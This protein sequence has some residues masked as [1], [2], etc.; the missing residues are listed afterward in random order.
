[1][2][3]GPGVTTI[4]GP[5]GCGKSN[6]V[7]AIRW[8][9]GEQSAKQLR[10]GKMQD[11]IFAGTDLR[12][13]LPECEVTLVF[14]E[15]E[16][17]L[18]TAYNE[19]EITRRVTREGGSNYSLNGKNCRL[20]DIQQLFMDTGV[21]RVSYSFMVQGQIDQILSTNPAERRV[22]FEE[23]AGITKYKSQRKETLGKLAQVEQ[24]LSR[25]NDI[26][27]EVGR[28]M[29]SLKRQ[30]SKAIRYQKVK[31]RLNH[32]D[33]AYS[34]FR[35]EQRDV[36]I[37]GLEE[38]AESLRNVV[39][40]LQ[41]SLEGDEVSLEEKREERSRI[42]EA[43]QEI[44]QA[45][46]DIRSKKEN[47]E[48]QAEVAKIRQKSAAERIETVEAEVEQLKGQ[49]IDLE[50]R[51]SDDSQVRQM[52]LDLIAGTDKAFS[53]KQTALE[54]VQQKLSQAEQSFSKKRSSLV[55]L[56]GD[57]ARLQRNCSS[58][59]VT[60]KTQ[61]AKAEDLKEQS[62]E[63]AQQEV[64]LKD[65]LENA[66]ANLKKAEE[67][68]SDAQNELE[69]L[70]AELSEARDTFKE[71]Q[72]AIQ[73]QDRELARVQ[74][75]LNILEGLQAKLE[76]FS[77]GAKA[78]LQGQVGAGSSEGGFVALAKTL[79]VPEE[80]SSA[81]E[82]LM[83]QSIDAIVAE[84]L[85]QAHAITQ[86]LAERDLGRA[87]LYVSV[88]KQK[89]AGA[90]GNLPK[91]IVPAVSVISS[92]DKKTVERLQVLL[93]GCYFSETLEDF[94]Q[95]WQEKPG[96]AFSFVATKD[97]ELVDARGLIFGG[98]RK[99][100]S[101][102]ASFIQ[103]ES[104]IRTLSEKLEEEKSSFEKLK[105]AGSEAQETLSAA[106]DAYE[107][108]RL[109]IQDCNRKVSECR[110]EGREA[111]NAWDRLLDLRNRHAQQLE[112]ISGSQENA[113]KQLEAG[114]NELSEQ[115]SKIEA[116][117]Q[118]V[119]EQ[120]IQIA[121]LREER[122]KVRDGVSE[123]RIELAEKRQRLDMLAQG[124]SKMDEQLKSIELNRAKLEKELDQLNDQIVQW[125]AESKDSQAQAIDL[126]K[127]LEEKT[128][129]LSSQKEKSIEQEEA[130]Q[131][132]ERELSARRK[133]LH[134]KENSLKQY[135][136][137]LVK[138]RSQ[139][140]FLIEKLRT[141]YDV[142]LSD[143]NWKM[144]LWHADEEFESKL[145][146][147]DLEDG[148]ELAPTVKHD[149]GEPTEE[150]FAAMEQTDWAA[151]ER[152][153]K[154][155]R[156]RISSMGAV[157]LVAI[158]EYTELKERHG[159][160]QKQC[161]DLANAKEQLVVAIE[162][163]NKTSEELFKETFEKVRENFKVTFL[164]LFG[165]GE[166][167]LT[168]MEG[169]DV[170]EA[171]IEITARP[172][173]TKLR[174]LSLLSGGQKTMTAVGLL[175]AIYQVKPSPFCVLDELDAPLDDA[176]IGRFTEMLREFTKYSQFLVISHNKRTISASDRLYGVTM[177]EK[178]VTRMISMKFNR[179][180]NKIEKQAA[181][182][183]V[184]VDEPLEAYAG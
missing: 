92:S 81:F 35:Y 87:C 82:V 60:L 23:A 153:I 85:S 25:A 103:R 34:G 112:A 94:I 3:L 19:V 38:K 115:L 167:D 119:S 22:I 140:E 52:Q 149:R 131:N 96:F 101:K 110:V 114:Q 120:E 163:I 49:V 100:A 184:P 75:Q 179:K 4:V 122:D 105:T 173:G 14:T 142:E 148:E 165:G 32:L 42:Y 56:E 129:S 8:V 89:S 126:E 135:D 9:L 144:E 12:Q 169:E 132:I 6:V 138:E 11:V 98:S 48:R 90:Q 31:H 150:D 174:S 102:G 30:A 79:K 157:N 10:G 26:I 88:E 177:Q 64:T 111:Q 175:F 43:L 40:D 143:V 77:E 5:N 104:E 137:N 80:Y 66:Q 69:S 20:K 116:A 160:L 146:L 145:K 156:D 72:R 97:G 134:E 164:K 21:G 74:A 180:E 154:E 39:V 130:I 155:L 158:Q 44:Q 62:Q 124:L 123:V 67:E 41:G 58:L 93:E 47:F 73:D 107:Q 78:I 68:L 17:A 99:K 95:F 151:I 182:E 136:V 181:P 159:F 108:K 125:E 161:D 27:D 162:D 2:A 55:Q 70:Q 183:E 59:E 84:D 28:Q 7:D 36:E 29:G 121:G 37:A 71:K 1:M 76:G 128:Q 133:E 147:D 54:A 51:A 65:R 63:T 141:E 57:I 171:G 117:K 118:E 53:E 106:E 109:E 139:M 83:G 15:C 91:E 170:L 13:Q 86:E 50:S 113:R 33:L 172:P 168:L 61:E 176:N 127:E 16:A 24:N 152:E 46:F 178:G 45:A 18:G 166:A